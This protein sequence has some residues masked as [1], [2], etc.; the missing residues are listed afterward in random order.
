MNRRELVRSLAAALALPALS[1]HDAARLIAA[2]RRA[3]HRAGPGAGAGVLDAHQRETVATMAELIIPTTDTPGARAAQVH[4]FI[5]LLLA[6]WA[7]DDQRAQFLAGLQD[8]D[9]RARTAYGT[10]FLTAT[11]AQRGELLKT[12]DAE[13]PAGGEGKPD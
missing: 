10:D 1:E 8:V 4:D 7:P 6:E 2:G 11:A 5:D 9:A 12:L 3:H 13:R